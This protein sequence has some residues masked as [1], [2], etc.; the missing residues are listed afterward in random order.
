MALSYTYSPNAQPS[1]PSLSLI[2]VWGC[3]VREAQRATVRE[4]HTPQELKSAVW[5]HK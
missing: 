1:R 4:A 2:N 3:C 5:K